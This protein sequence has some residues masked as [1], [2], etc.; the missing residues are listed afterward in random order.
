MD[1]RNAFVKGNL[2][3]LIR[4]ED[5]LAAPPLLPLCIQAN[6][7]KLMICKPKKLIYPHGSHNMIETLIKQALAPIQSYN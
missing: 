6:S 2:N 4:R 7:D 3:K 5:V 1:M